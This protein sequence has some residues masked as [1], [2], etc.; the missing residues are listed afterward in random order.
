MVR[1]RDL[2]KRIDRQFGLTR[3]A[4]RPLISVVTVGESLTLGAIWK[5]GPTKLDALRAMLN[6]LVVIG[7]RQGDIVDRY[8]AL[9]AHCKAHGL[10]LSDNDRWIAATARAAGAVLLT[11]DK[12]FDHLHP[13][14]IQRIYIDPSSALP[15]S[16]GI[17]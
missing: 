6:E 15:P 10:T 13:S 8:A 7:L 5:W 1:N 11:T 2:G 17:P 14:H 3:R 12:D 4:D 16:S 9:S